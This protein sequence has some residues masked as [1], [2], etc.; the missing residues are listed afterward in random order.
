M[1]GFFVQASAPVD[2]PAANMDQPA[3]LAIVMKVIGRTGS[4]GQVTQVRSLDGC[5][6]WVVHDSAVHLLLSSPGGKAGLAAVIAR[7]HSRSAT[8]LVIVPVSCCRTKAG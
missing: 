5:V 3:K 1:L 7:E 8:A 6:G 2:S 4:R